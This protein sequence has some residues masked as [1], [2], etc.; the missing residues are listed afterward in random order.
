MPS[1]ERRRGDPFP[2]SGV[3]DRARRAAAACWRGSAALKDWVESSMVG[4]CFMSERRAQSVRVG[5]FNERD[6]GVSAARAF[7]PACQSRGTLPGGAG[8]GR[9]RK[10]V[11]QASP[12]SWESLARSP[13]RRFSLQSGTR[14]G[15]GCPPGWRLAL[16]RG[17]AP[18]AAIHERDTGSSPCLRSWP[19]NGPARHLRSR[20]R[21]FG[22]PYRVSSTGHGAPAFLLCGFELP[23][24]RHES[25]VAHA[26]FHAQLTLTALQASVRDNWSSVLC[27]DK[28]HRIVLLLPAV[29][30]LQPLNGIGVKPLGG[31]ASIDVGALLDKKAAVVF[32]TYAADFNAIEYGQRLRHYAP[33]LKERG[34]ESLH[35]ILNA[36]EAASEKFVELLGLE[37]V[38]EVYCDPTG[39]AGRAFG[40]G[41]GWLPDEDS[42]FDGH[43]HQRLRQ[44]LRHAAR[45]RRLGHITSSHRRLHRQP[46]EGPALDRGRD[47]PGPVAGHGSC[48]VWKS[49]F[50]AR[51]PESRYGTD[52]AEK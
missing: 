27:I 38:C 12:G 26:A 52:A 43:S 47:G 21:L 45:S 14:W 44:A 25:S 36:D 11:L 3:T 31:A 40:C 51:W 48:S 20:R 42:L 41:R 32:G 35:L 16:G 29:T 33:K 4:P 1:L 39:A 9:P 37:G 8:H 24:G 15:R 13:P 28:M 50:T 19:K 5:L 23:G 22:P 34:V 30:A 46:L 2:E 6:S 49:K 10:F 7:C 18:Q 17:G